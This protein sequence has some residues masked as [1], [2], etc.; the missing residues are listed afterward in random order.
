MQ[1]TAPKEF[2]AGPTDLL[3]LTLYRVRNVD[4]VHPAMLN[5]DHSASAYPCRSTVVPCRNTMRHR[6]RLLCR[7]WRLDVA[8]DTA[9][10]LSDVWLGAA[11]R[12]VG[13]WQNRPRQI[14]SSFVASHHITKSKQ[15]KVDRHSVR[16]KNFRDKVGA[17]KHQ[18]QPSVPLNSLAHAVMLSKLA[19]IRLSGPRLM[20]PNN[21]LFAQLPLS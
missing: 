13:P 21:V 18:R 4:R 7:S 12:W 3:L 6:V 15:F 19:S 14:G 8:P 2:L 5:R 17:G 20:M 10:Y 11:D 16:A 9:R 1:Q